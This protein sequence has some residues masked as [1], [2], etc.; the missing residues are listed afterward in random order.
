LIT[1]VALCQAGRIERHTDVTV[2]RMRP[3]ER[4]ELERYVADDEPLDCAGAYKVESRGIALFES[5]ESADQT[6]ISGLPLIAVTGL[7]RRI[8]FVIP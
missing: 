3:L 7:L 4:S 1:A 2:L 8:G 6:A 5:I